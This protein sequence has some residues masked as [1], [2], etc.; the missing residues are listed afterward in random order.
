MPDWNVHELSIASVFCPFVPAGYKTVG[1]TTQ[2]F[3]AWPRVAAILDLTPQCSKPS[4]K[5]TLSV[6][7]SRLYILHATSVEHMGTSPRG[8]S[9]EPPDSYPTMIVQS[10]LGTAAPSC[11]QSVTAK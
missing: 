11:E 5:S 9:A 1:L 7:K 4:I 8:V 2:T 10:A 6:G 3:I